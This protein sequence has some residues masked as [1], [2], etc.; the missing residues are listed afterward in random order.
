MGGGWEGDWNSQS[1]TCS[2]SALCVTLTG[3]WVEWNVLKM[4]TQMWPM[5]SA[6]GAHQHQLVIKK[7]VQARNMILNNRTTMDATTQMGNSQ[8]SA[9]MIIHYILG[10][11]KVCTMWVSQQPPP[12]FCCIYQ[13]NTSGTGIWSSWPLAILA[14][15]EPLEETMRCCQFADEE[16]KEVVHDLSPRWTKNVSF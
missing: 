3:V 5:Q 13:R 11:H 2:I 12:P 7:Q 15:F 10:Y 6:L 8:G 16:M 9:H 1:F 4:A 14:M